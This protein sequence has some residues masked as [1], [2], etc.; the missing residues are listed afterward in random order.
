MLSL[1]LF[2]SHPYTQYNDLVERDVIAACREWIIFDTRQSE[3]VRG[4]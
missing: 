1:L 2:I 4:Y 3:R